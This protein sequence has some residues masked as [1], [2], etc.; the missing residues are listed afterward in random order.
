MLLNVPNIF[1]PEETEAVLRSLDDAGPSLWR[2]GASSAFGAAKEVKKNTQC[3]QEHPAVVE[4]L[5]KA[6]I[7]LLKNSAFVSATQPDKFSKLMINAYE[8][9]MSY[10]RHYDAPYIR[11]VRTDISITLFLTPPT[12]YAGGDLVLT[13]PFCEMSVKGEQGG[14]FLYPSTYLHR[15]EPVTSGRRI[16]IV[17]WLK[18]KIRQPH[19]REILFDLDRSISAL[20]DD[21]A[22]NGAYMDLIG[23]KN[24]LLREWAD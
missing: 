6:R 8:P 4:I 14:V 11:D 21:T 22:K 12:S 7:A 20:V 18:S 16:A 15:V 17:G 23:V 9:G 2:D 13:T 24:K 19:Q 3:N 1:S 5:E 10:G